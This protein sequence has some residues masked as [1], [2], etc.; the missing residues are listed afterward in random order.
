DVAEHFVI[1]AVVRRVDDPLL[2]PRTPGV[3]TGRGERDSAR[4]RKRAKLL[5]PLAEERGR[6]G[7]RTTAAGADLD[8]RRDQLAHEVRLELRSLRCLL[9]LLEAVDEAERLGIDERKLL[10]D[11]HRE[12]GNGLE[13]LAREREHLLVAE[14]LPLAHRRSLLTLQEREVAQRRPA[15]SSAAPLRGG[16]LDRARGGALPAV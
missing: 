4:L 15:S 16:R 2:L 3:R 1:E 12:I 7:E 6:V 5:P 10:L 14:L 9:E 13:R 11:G 8:L